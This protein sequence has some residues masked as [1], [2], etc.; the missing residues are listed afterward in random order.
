MGAPKGNQFWRQR[1]KHGRD[2]LFCSSD[3]IWEAACEYFQWS[4]E[5]PWIKYEAIKSGDMAGQLVSIPTARPYTMHGLCSYLG[6]NTA[7]FREFKERLTEN[8]KDFS[9]VITRV[10]ETIYQQKFEGAAVNALNANIISRDLG[11]ID[12]KDLTSKGEKL[13][14]SPSVVKVEIIRPDFDD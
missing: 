9:T 8:D 1:T 12:A 7:Y 4:D 5:N 6:V 14:H 3:L 2:A 10:E 11:L 13:E